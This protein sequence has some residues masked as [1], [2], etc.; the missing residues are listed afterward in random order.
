M[1]KLISL[2]L[3]ILLLNA[4][5]MAQINKNIGAGYFGHL[6]T[7]PGIVLEYEWEFVHNE[8]VSTPLRLD[9]GMYVHPRNHIGIFADLNYGVRKT[10]GSGL[11]LEESI[12]VGVLESVLNGDAVYAPV[13]DGQLEEISRFTPPNLMPSVTFGI[14]YD[15]SK[16]SDSSTMVWL[17]PKLYWQFPHKTSST[18]HPALQVG[19]TRR[20]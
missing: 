20:L 18:F 7:H 9:L 8:K 10:F 11:F 6:I 4:F 12:G 3:L 16:K 13:D 1:K 15:L 2:C 5:S 17:R 19:V 14:G